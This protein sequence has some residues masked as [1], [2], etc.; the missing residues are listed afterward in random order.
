MDKS[1]HLI[2]K[3]LEYIDSIA[4]DFNQR[5]FKFERTNLVCNSILIIKK[6]ANPQILKSANLLY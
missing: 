5:N 4:V 1:Y 3:I 2:Y 6:T